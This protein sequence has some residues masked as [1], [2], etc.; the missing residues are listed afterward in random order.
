MKLKVLSTGSN[1]NCYLLQTETETL[2]LDCGISIKEIKKGLN[3]DL[4]KVVGCVVTHSHKDHSLSVKD[5][6]NMGINVWQPYLEQNKSPKI[7]FGGF[8]IRSF[9]VPHDDTSC[10]GFMIEAP[11]GD[12]ILYATDFE[13]IKYSF[14]KMN[15]QHFL[16]ECNYQN[17]YVDKSAENRNHVLKGHAELQTTLGIIKDNL[18]SLKTV[19]LCHLSEKNSIPEECVVETK[20]V[21]KHNVFVDYARKGLEVELNNNDCPF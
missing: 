19:I 6:E 2:I 3:F 11:G 5:F 8:S 1:G 17:E 16:I 13:Y 7:K 12:K 14:R 20:K 4:S 18:D 21:V 15:I 10:C 9:D